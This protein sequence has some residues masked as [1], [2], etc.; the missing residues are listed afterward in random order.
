MKYFLFHSQYFLIHKHQKPYILI[1]KQKIPYI[2]IHITVVHNPHKLK[3]VVS[4][5]QNR[6]SWE[7]VCPS[8]Q[9]HLLQLNIL[10]SN[11]VPKGT[12]IKCTPKNAEYSCLKNSGQDKYL[13]LSQG[14]KTRID[15]W[16]S[17]LFSKNYGERF[18]LFF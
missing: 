10:I 13:I 9:P 2:L 6:S 5:P 7:T 12:R 17:I 18:A 8:Q 1:H 3:T 14:Q 11:Y 15:S 16:K 4:N